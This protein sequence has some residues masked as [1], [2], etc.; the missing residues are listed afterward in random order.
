MSKTTKP[1]SKPKRKES[2]FIYTPATKQDPPQWNVCTWDAPTCATHYYSHLGTIHPCP[3][4]PED[5]PNGE[6]LFTYFSHQVIRL[7]PYSP[8]AAIEKE[9]ALILRKAQEEHNA[10]S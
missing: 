6:L 5:A 2:E 8:T 10:Q 3:L 4:N 9:A 1:K 7:S